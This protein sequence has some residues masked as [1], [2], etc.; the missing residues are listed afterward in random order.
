M[1]RIIT[2]VLGMKANVEDFKCFVTMTDKFLTGW[3]CAEKK[4]AKRVYLCK[5]SRTAF[6]LRDRITNRKNSGMT[7]VNVVYSFPKYPASRYVTTFD[8][9][10]ETAFRW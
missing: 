5:D 8:L 3:G 9:N 6:E 4:I 7:Y 1:C 2:D 10:A